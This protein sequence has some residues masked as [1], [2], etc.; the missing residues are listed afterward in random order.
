[1]ANGIDPQSLTPSQLASFQSQNPAVQQKS[2][3]VYAQTVAQHY[4]KSANHA[5]PDYETQLMALEQQ[6]KKRL[7]MARQEQDVNKGPGEAQAEETTSIYQQLQR[8]P[9]N[10][11]P[12]NTD[13]AVPVTVRDSFGS[14]PFELPFGSTSTSHSDGGPTSSHM[15]PDPSS[16]CSPLSS[17]AEHTAFSKVVEE[18]GSNTKTVT[19]KQSEVKPASDTPDSGEGRSVTEADIQRLRDYIEELELANQRYRSKQEQWRPRPPRWQVL[20]RISNQE[21]STFFDHPSWV[22]TSNESKFLQGNNPVSNLPLY[23]K[24]NKGISFIVTRTSMRMTRPP[25]VRI[26][27]TQIV[28]D[29]LLHIASPSIPSLLHYHGLLIS[30]FN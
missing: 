27:R 13:K 3:Q 14:N 16:I 29:F 28:L 26:N 18:H 2:I 24:K 20:H 11:T 22:P 10:S 17:A 6:N 1:M 25:A 7:M 5:L 19:T 4:K 8:L 30:C 23:L 15:E 9:K 21:H 12:K